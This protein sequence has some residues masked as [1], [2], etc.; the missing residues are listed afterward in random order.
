MNINEKL[1]TN[2]ELIEANVL[3]GNA[4]GELIDRKWGNVTMLFSAQNGKITTIKINDEKIFK[5]AKDS[6]EQKS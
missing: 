4:L 6:F 3:V 5:I 1:A 2:P